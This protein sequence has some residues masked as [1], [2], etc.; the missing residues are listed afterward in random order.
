MSP[1]LIVFVA[2]NIVPRDKDEGWSLLR[3]LRSF[4]IVDLYLSFEAHTDQT[5]ADGQH[6]LSNFA[7]RMEVRIPLLSSM[8]FIRNIC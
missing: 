6:E 5:L 2:L 4:T 7:Q 1:Q 3:C 8:P